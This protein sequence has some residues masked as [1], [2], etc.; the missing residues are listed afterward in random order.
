MRIL[1]FEYRG[2][3]DPAWHI[4]RT[5]FQRE[6]NLFVG[7]S[8]AGKTRIMTILF[9]VGTFVAQ[10]SPAFFEGIW[11]LVFESEGKTYFWNYEGYKS[12]TGNNIKKEQ[13]VKEG[14]VLAERTEQGLFFDNNKMPKLAEDI[15]VITLFKAED[16]ISAAHRAFEKMMRRSFSGDEL[17]KSF[18]FASLPK[19]LVDTV[20]ANAGK[21]DQSFIDIPIQ[22]RLYLL[23]EFQSDKFNQIKDQF[24]RVFPSIESLEI[25]KL[26]EGK[27]PFVGEAPALVLRERGGNAEFLGNDI[28]S[29]MRKVLLIITDIVSTT[30][31]F[32][33]IIDEYEN[34]LGINAIDFLP[35]FIAECGEKK[36]FL[37]TSHH[38][39]LINAIPVKSWLICQRKGLEITVHMGKD[40]EDRYGKS[41]HQR[42]IQLINDPIYSGLLKE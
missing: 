17:D 26:A 31:D 6:L 37:V 25:K 29:G 33:H 41:R 18:A 28:S 24:L 15:S 30:P 9:N 39:Y 7:A 11:S 10:G 42:F 32:L 20:K 1:E 2:T 40:L 3:S 36:Q 12:S 14:K 13:L 19:N 5:T 34:S 23:K 8:G 4:T 27:I 22:L 21:V 16:Q 38:P 35:P